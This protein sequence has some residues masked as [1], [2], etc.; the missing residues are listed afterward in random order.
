[1]TA[2]EAPRASNRTAAL[3]AGI[4]LFRPINLLAIALASWVGSRLGHAPFDLPRLLVPVLIAAYGYARNDATDAAPDRWNRPD[5]PVASGL[6]APRTAWVL[7]LLP[8][9][10]AVAILAS[11]S[12]APAPFVVA[13]GAAILL[14]AYSPWL[15]NA[16]PAGPA[17]IAL[18]TVLAVI[19]GGLPGS[20]PG[21]ALIPALLAGCAQFAREC[22]KQLEDAPGDRASGRGTWAVRAGGGR[23][24]AAARAALLGSLLILPLP[25]PASGVAARYLWLAAP[26][27][28]LPLLW[29]YTSLGRPGARHGAISAA[30]K[31]A[32][33]AGLAGLAWGA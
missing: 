28:G 24:T 10:A 29:A 3:F 11:R 25:V 33:F 17:T 23:V 8:L 18:L 9:A 2:A 30:I 16:G 15:K 20:A 27:A 1:V 31:G 22:V 26:A 12:L 4:R 19:W 32:L 5:R 14:T 7:S 6:V 13:A 21:R